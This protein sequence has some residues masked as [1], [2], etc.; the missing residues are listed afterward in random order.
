MSTADI[1]PGPLVTRRARL[2]F[3]AQRIRGRERVR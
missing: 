3:A 1:D 2:L